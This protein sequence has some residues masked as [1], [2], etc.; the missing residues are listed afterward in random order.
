[1]ISRNAAHGS[2]LTFHRPRHVTLTKL[3]TA[4]GGRQKAVNGSQ[5]M[6]H[7]PIHTTLTIYNI[8]G[9]KVRT[10]VNEPK[11]PGTCGVTWDAKDKNG[12]EVAS[13]VYFNM[14]EAKDLAQAKKMVL[15][16][17]QENMIPNN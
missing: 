1:V 13:G 9:Q 7:D 3:G 10:L 14:L 6:V 11:E 5:F 8:V 12:D 2:Q 17:W 4:D 15:M 16:Q